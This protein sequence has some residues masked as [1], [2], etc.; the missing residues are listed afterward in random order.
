MYNIKDFEVGIMDLRPIG[1]FDS[2]L[3]GISFLK[4]AYALMP[5]ENFIYYGDNKHAPYGR[6]SEGEIQTLS[7][8]CAD[9]LFNKNVKAIVIACIQR[10]VQA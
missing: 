10:R 4:E 3:G 7:L 5:N 6:K 8:A 2:G 9:F 1:I